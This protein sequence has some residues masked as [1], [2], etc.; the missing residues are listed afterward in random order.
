MIHLAVQLVKAGAPLAA[1]LALVLILAAAAMA[2]G[3]REATAQ[4][5]VVIPR[6][7][8]VVV[9]GNQRI[10]AETIQTYLGVAQGD[11]VTADQVNAAVRRLYETELFR[12]VA[13]TPQGGVLLVEVVENPWINRVAFEGVD[14]VNE[15]DL[16]GAIQSAPRKA[17]TRALGERDARAIRDLYAR[18]GRFD[19]KVEVRTEDQPQNRVDVFFVID[20]GEK[21]GVNDIEFEGNERFSDRRLRGVIETSESGILAWVF[22]GDVYDPDRLEFDKELLRRFYLNRG[23]ADFRVVD[24]TAT[25]D[26]DGEGYNITFVVEEGPVYAIGGLEVRAEF[27]GIEQEALLAQLT[28][29]TGD[30]YDAEEVDNSI[31]NLLFLAGQ[32]GFAFATVEPRAEKRPDTRTIDLIFDMQ[33]GARVYVERIEI[34]G[35]SRTLDR[36]LRREFRISEGDA[37]NA[38]EI[39]NATQRLRALGYFRTVEVTTERGSADDRAVI[40]VVVTENLTGSLSIGVGYDTDQGVNS[41]LAISERNFLGRGQTIS[42]RVAYAGDTQVF[43]FGFR[44]PKLLDRDLSAGFRV[45][46]RQEDLDDESSFEET[47]IGFVPSVRFPLSPVSTLEVSYR[48]SSDEIRDVADDASAAIKA[49]EGTAIT[50]AVG[51]EYVYDQRNDRI[52]TTAG[53]LLS[54]KQ[55]VAGLGGDSYYL[56]SVARAKAWTS[57]FDEAVVASLEVE[58]GAIFTIGDD[59]RV[60]DR[61][62]IG[63]ASLRG[64]KARGVGPRDMTTDDALGGN[65]YA[66]TRAEVS[67]PLGL[68]EELGMF[69]GLFA[70]AGTLWGLDRTEY[71][72]VTIDDEAHLRAAVGATLF[73]ATPFGPLQFSLAYPVVSEEGDNKQYFRFSVGTRF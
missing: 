39:R 38:R 71:G 1:R 53:Y 56:R 21:T 40:K 49:D 14:A 32:E 68:P 57:F 4:A 13:I 50:S 20:E 7:E 55:D 24:A 29:A 61:F 64:F 5:A 46:F 3:A 33:E 30:I 45:Y 28:M 10:E 27:T 73:M 16:L 17:Y 72:A 70:D 44:E 26:A 66:V 22:G 23:Y 31:E 43:E 67:F 42:A 11:R 60:T 48:I 15:E 63:G 47:N 36:V 9:Q 25:L 6:L 35:N 34:E 8:Q 52:E 62:F 37:F 18:V 19:A 12:D 59:L 54:A 41:D 2:P 51:L 65:Y 69:G 58:G